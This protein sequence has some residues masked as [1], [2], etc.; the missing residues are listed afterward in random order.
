MKWIDDHTPSCMKD[1]PAQSPD[2]NPMEN[3]WAIL[4][5]QIYENC[6]KTISGLK[7]KI[8]L[9]YKNFSD[10]IIENCINSFPRRLRAVIKAK[11][12]STKY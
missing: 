11:G 6:P 12:G 9:F 3:I 1:W 7:R 4:A 5:Q 2:L 10:K 8:E